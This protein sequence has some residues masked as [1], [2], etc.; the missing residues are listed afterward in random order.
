MRER[1]SKDLCQ[2]SVYV[3]PHEVGQYGRV[4]FDRL[5]IK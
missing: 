1:T 2:G 5:N 4:T 3:V